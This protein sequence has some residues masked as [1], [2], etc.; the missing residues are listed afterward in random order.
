MSQTKPILLVD[1]NEDDVF[2]TRRALK[3]AG[4][5]IPVFVV[6]NGQRAIDYLSGTGSYADRAA[7]PL[8]GLVLLDL[9]L[10]LKSGHEVLAWI[11]QNPKF[12]GLIVLVLT[13]SNNA[14]DVAACYKLRANSYLVKPAG[15]EQLLN[16][17]KALKAFWLDCNF[18]PCD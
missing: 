16:V 14:A 1:D 5:D 17:A 13:S 7:F 4:I 8:P 12:D 9:K 6:E 18:F 10:P 11:R 3:D 15:R 2:L